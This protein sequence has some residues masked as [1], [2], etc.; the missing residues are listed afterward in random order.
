[1]KKVDT[2]TRLASLAIFMFVL[3]FAISFLGTVRGVKFAMN[4][5]VEISKANASGWADP[6]LYGL[7]NDEKRDLPS[8]LE[9]IK[10]A[11]NNDYGFYKKG[12]PIKDIRIGATNWCSTTYVDLGR[13]QKESKASARTA[14]LQRQIKDCD[15]KEG[16]N[17]IYKNIKELQNCIAREVGSDKVLPFGRIYNIMCRVPNAE[18]IVKAS[19]S[20]DLRVKNQKQI[21]KLMLSK[22]GGKTIINIPK[23]CAKELKTVLELKKKGL[24]NTK[25]KASFAD[26][27]NCEY[28]GVARCLL[29]EKAADILN[30]ES[31]QIDSQAG[32]LRINNLKNSARDKIR[33]MGY[34]Y[35]CFPKNKKMGG[36]SAGS[37]SSTPPQ[38]SG[39][40][41]SSPP[42]SYGRSQAPYGQR[43]QQPY[44]S[45]RPQQ[46]TGVPGQSMGQQNYDPCK[47]P[48]YAQKQNMGFFS[49][50]LFSVNCAL[51]SKKDDKKKENDD[52]TPSCV[53]SASK[54]SINYGEEV[55][56]RWKSIN[57]N[58]A[59]LSGD[60][61]SA[62]GL[63]GSKTVKPTKTATYT[64]E[65]KNRNGKTATCSKTVVVSGSDKEANL[66]CNPDILK[67]GD[68]VQLSW[69]C[70]PG[71][72]LE[73]SNFGATENSGSI[74][75]SVSANT[76]YK[77]TCSGENSDKKTAQC[78]VN[79]ANPQYEIIAFP[80]EVER[81][82]KIRVSWGATQMQSCRVTGPQGFDYKRDYAV[83]LTV[84]FPKDNRIA[85]DGLV[86]YTLTCTDRW[87]QE[88]SKDVTVKLT[89]SVSKP[90][91]KQPVHINKPKTQPR[92][93]VTTT[94]RTSLDPK[95]C[96]HFTKYYKLG[97]S[98][99]EVPKI[100]IFLK[101]QGLYRGP[102]NGIYNTQVDSAIRAFQARYADEILRPWKLTA[103]T[104]YWYKTTRKKA[105]ELAGCAEGA[106]VLD[107]GSVVY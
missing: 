11:K 70:P 17:P 55:T 92:D 14:G 94:I 95:Q 68:T 73:E 67:P 61:I 50:M 80:E 74:P 54:T 18:N 7:S 37:P 105:N 62:G 12:L 83:V 21:E 106:V 99:G 60:G 102:M 33:E 77:I 47:D 75:L 5:E 36:S 97:S 16:N 84:P 6:K 53:I 65:V 87:G 86:T 19:V 35:N 76:T 89:G 88:Y 81:G 25:T 101:D 23:K 22:S 79:M 42:G 90:K 72:S 8:A 46:G 66:S 40:G 98:G 39:G 3:V 63:S 30:N 104:G 9:Q 91:K 52:K 44:G 69:S 10:W 71:T 49:S 28:K 45:A 64:L 13:G 59:A 93:T 56:L 24:D 96:P 1:M 34:V 85:K 27:N 38:L 78:S 31:N 2:N 15:G 103:P 58:I 51:N 82:G 57:A 107:D 4:K 20:E 29:T 48:T 32:G 100:Q 41:V 43:W 26:R